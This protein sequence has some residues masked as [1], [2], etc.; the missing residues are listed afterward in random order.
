MASKKSKESFHSLNPDQKLVILSDY[1]KGKIHPLMYVFKETKCLLQTQ[2]PQIAVL[3]TERLG[4]LISI[5]SM[6]EISFL[7]DQDFKKVISDFFQQATND[8]DFRFSDRFI[9]LLIKQYLLSPLEIPESVIKPIGQLSESSGYFYKRLDFD[10]DNFDETPLFDEMMTRCTNS[11]ELM[12]FIGMIFYSDSFFDAQKYLWIYGNTGSGKGCIYRFLHA[13]LGK[14]ETTMS[15]KIFNSDHGLSLA[16]GKR[17]LQFD[18]AL[19]NKFINEANMMSHV[20]GGSSIINDKYEKIYAIKL[21]YLSIVYSNKKPNIKFD[22]QMR[23]VIFVK[24][25]QP[26]DHDMSEIYETR[27]LLEGPAWISKCVDKF[28]ANMTFEMFD[29]GAMELQKENNYMMD[30][31]IEKN[32]IFSQNVMDYANRS[33]IANRLYNYERNFTPNITE[34]FR[35]L[36]HNYNVQYV[37]TTRQ[38]VHIRGYF[39][40]K[41]T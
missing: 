39:Y 37:D 35:Y 19:D 25:Q 14:V 21:N 34:F 15:T 18:E 24:M 20:G 11:E 27:L 31:F 33:E 5:N 28:R 30:E 3:K 23:R 32:L 7:S 2:F 40:V 12:R 29:K 1:M 4:K 41:L 13:I 26:L 22:E 17:L 36:E 6:A 10:F 8:I 38:K 9:G 16:V